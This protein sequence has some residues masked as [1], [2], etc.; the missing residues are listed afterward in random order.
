[1]YYTLIE[2]DNDGRWW[3]QFGD[4]KKSVVDA[5]RRDY[6]DRREYPA[7]HYKIVATPSDAQSEI[8]SVIE[9]LNRGAAK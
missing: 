3:P 4:Y 8:D 5:E 6:V 2:K 1:M 9:V 7:S